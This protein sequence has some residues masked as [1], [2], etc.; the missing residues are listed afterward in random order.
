MLI[1][2]LIG[3]GVLIAADQLLKYWA[4]QVL[5]PVGMMPFLRIGDVEILDFHYLENDG[6][7]FSSFS[8]MRW[9]LVACTSVMILVCFYYLVRHYRDSHVLTIGLSL[10]IAGGI[11][12]L[13]DRLFRHGLVVDYIE[14]KLFHFAVFNFADCCVTIGVALLAI[15][16]LLPGSKAKQPND[17]V[18]I[19][20]ESEESTD[21]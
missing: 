7:V 10:V 20:A 21:A 12:N 6:A 11:G 9:V 5:R 13:I 8:G 14:V 18:E 2:A 3:I 15:S 19:E 16:F 4:V 1:A 17:S